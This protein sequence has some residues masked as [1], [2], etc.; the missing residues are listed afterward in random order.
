[1]VSW[2]KR[3]EFQAAFLR[4]YMSLHRV[5]EFERRKDVQLQISAW[6]PTVQIIPLEEL[7]S[8]SVIAG[9]RLRGVQ[10]GHDSYS[11]HDLL[12]K[13]EIL[14]KHGVLILGSDSTTGYGKSQFAKRLAVS[15]SCAICEGM[16]LPRDR[17]KVVITNTIDAAKDIKFEPGMV[18]I[19]DELCAK[20]REQV[21]YFSE[22]IFKVLM[23]PSESGS[24]RARNEDIVLPPHVARIVTGNADNVEDWLGSRSQWSLPLQRKCIY[25]QLNR[26]CC[27]SSWHAQ[28]STD[29]DQSNAVGGALGRARDIL[30]KDF[31]AAFQA[32]QERENRQATAGGSFWSRLKPW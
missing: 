4:V 17:A 6:E 26:T 1:M 22:N 11:F 14:D 32:C 21:I 15:W 31:D 8:L 7:V 24:I 3:S 27:S 25:F 30:M 13:P 9:C 20:D 29:A 23:T 16:G 19:L 5:L 2:Q 28:T 10:A 12:T 18:W